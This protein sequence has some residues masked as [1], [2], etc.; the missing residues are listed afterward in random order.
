MKITATC[1]SST[2]R[3]DRT[4]KTFYRGLQELERI[5]REGE[6]KEAAELAAAI[7]YFERTGRNPPG[8]DLSLEIQH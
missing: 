8:Y 4:S 7:E 1:D 2:G 6:H 3:S 5:V